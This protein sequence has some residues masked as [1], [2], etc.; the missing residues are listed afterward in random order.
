MGHHYAMYPHLHGSRIFISVI[1]FYS[2]AVMNYVS[3]YLYPRFLPEQCLCASLG[4]GAGNTNDFVMLSIS[5]VF[6]PVQCDHEIRY[7]LG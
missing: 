4:K 5:T 1:A 7:S 3:N 2:V 6:L